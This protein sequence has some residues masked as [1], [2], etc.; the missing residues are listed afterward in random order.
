MNGF[1]RIPYKL[2]YLALLVMALYA[3]GADADDSD[4]PA[5]SLN[6]F[7]TLGVVHSSE[8][9]ADFNSSILKPNGAGY[10]HKWSPD[11]DSLLGVQG[12]AK[13]TPRLTAVMQIISE[14]NYDKTYRP[15]VEWANIQ[16]QATPDISVRAGRIVLP[17]F[18]FSDSQKVAYTHPWVRPPLEIYHMVPVTA[19]DGVDAS[20]R[21]HV[22]EITNAININIGK[23]NNKLANDRGTIEARRSWGVNYSGDYHASTWH[24]GYQSTHLTLD[25]VNPFFDGFR[26]FG[27]PGIAIA[28]QYDVDNKVLSVITI[29]ARYDPGSWFIIGEWGHLVTHSFLGKET[30]WYASG[31]HRFG[32]FTPY[33]TYAHATADNR[34]DPGL[35]LT[36]LPPPQIATA[37]GLNAALNSLLSSKFVQNT[38]SIGGRWDLTRRTAFKLQFDHTNIGAGSNGVLTNT[39]P[40]FQTGGEV[41]IVSATIDFVF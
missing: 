25:G 1:E 34:T 33:L 30:A 36:T 5:F 26:Q 8:N 40:G 10:S 29:G 39:Q 20:Y 14:Q 19:S 16:Y 17:T 12:T 24:I 11:V 13:I 32:S 31:G 3:V 9:Q 15:H 23:S 27:P 35:D 38:V 6:G 2:A 21:T 22:N 18:L 41:N 28:D 37:A 4:M 7:G